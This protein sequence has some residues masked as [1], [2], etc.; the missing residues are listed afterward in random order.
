MIMLRIRMFKNYFPTLVLTEF[1]SV[2]NPYRHLSPQSTH[3]TFGESQHPSFCY[4]ANSDMHAAP[5]FSYNISQSKIRPLLPW[6]SVV[7]APC[8][9]ESWHMS[10]NGHLKSWAG[11]RKY[12]V[13]V[14]RQAVNLA[15]L[16]LFW[17]PPDL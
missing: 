6:L 2:M 9:L 3:K 14:L 10:T 1:D 8:P 17:F 5:N 4:T 12:C 7:Q 15:G 13:V 11:R 16:L